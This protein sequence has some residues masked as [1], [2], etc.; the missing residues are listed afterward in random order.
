M[1]QLLLLVVFLAYLILGFRTPAGIAGIIDSNVGK[2]AKTKVVDGD[3]TDRAHGTGGIKE[4]NAGGFKKGGKVPGLGRAI[5][6][7]D[8]ENRPADTSKPGKTGGTTGGVKEANAGGYK[9][10]GTAKKA[11]AAGG[12]VVDD[13]KAVKMPPRIKHAPVANTMQSGTFK[14]GGKVGKY[15]EAGPVDAKAISDKASRE[16]EEALNPLSMAKELYGKARNYF[17]GEQTAPGAVTKTKESVT[18][19]PK[20]RGGRAG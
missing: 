16:L 9:K 5:E 8:W 1:P 7:G 14:K 12:N 13:G 4:A 17:R 15:A 20:K 11:Y 2:F 10:G 3:K 19:S 6:G 18:V